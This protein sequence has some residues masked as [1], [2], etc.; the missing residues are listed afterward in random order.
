MSDKKVG[1]S[2]VN[3]LCKTCTKRCKQ[4]EQVTVVC[5]PNYKKLAKE[6]KQVVAFL[7]QFCKPIC[8]NELGK[9]EIN[10]DVC[11]ILLCYKEL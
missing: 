4:F 5:C 2:G 10:G 8:L 9:W 7:E 11:C 1:L 3:R 6:E